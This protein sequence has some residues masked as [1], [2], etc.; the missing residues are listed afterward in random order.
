MELSRERFSGRFGVRPEPEP[1]QPND[2]PYSARTKL[3]SAIDRLR[4]RGLP[5]AT[6]LGPRLADALGKPFDGPGDIVKIRGLILSLEWW[7]FYDACEELLRM[8]GGLSH[9]NV[10]EE[11]E[12]IFT[13]EALPYRFTENGIEWRLAQSTTLAIQTAEELLVG[14][15]RFRGPAEQWTK[16]ESHLSRRPPDPENCIK[17]SVGALEGVARIISG[18]H[19]DTLAQ[20]LPSLATTLGIH[21]TL[22]N[23]LAR[24]YAYRGDEQAIAHGAVEALRDLAP[25]AELVLHW[26]ASAIVFLTQKESAGRVVDSIEN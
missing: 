13:E 8:S 6:S 18:R 22:K 9:G 16:A 25:E 12:A 2:V 26:A 19:N 10:V 15:E 4:Q 7:E 23:A 20:I 14:D 21:G 5:G 17:D 24:L 3:I 11:L 1:R